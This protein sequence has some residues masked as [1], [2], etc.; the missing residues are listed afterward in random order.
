MLSAWYIL[1]VDTKFHK[2]S[3]TLNADGVTVTTSTVHTPQSDGLSEREQETV[4]SL[5]HTALQ[6]AKRPMRCWN[7]AIRHV[8]ICKNCVP[9]LSTQEKSVWG[10]FWT[11][12]SGHTIPQTILMWHDVPA[13][14][15]KSARFFQSRPERSMFD[16]WWK[17]NLRCSYRY[18][19][20]A[21]D[22][23][24]RDGKKT[25]GT[26]R[27]RNCSSSKPVGK[28]DGHVSY[29]SFRLVT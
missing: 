8:P 4:L 21:F 28:S 14:S 12:T 23:C 25:S 13:T 16:A 5:A 27:L 2:D 24:P 9:S 19:D 29:F 20:C 17:W 15:E 26:S 10:S 3:H 1:M 7:Y 18:L 22:A 6:E 11:Y